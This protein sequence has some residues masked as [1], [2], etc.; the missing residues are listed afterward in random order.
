MSSTHHFWIHRVWYGGVYDVHTPGAA[1]GRRAC[2]DRRAAR[3]IIPPN[4]QIRRIVE[5]EDM[6][7]TGHRQTMLFSATFPKEV[8][9]RSARA[10]AAAAS[11]GNACAVLPTP[12]PPNSNR[13]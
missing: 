12:L 4:S 2:S 1:C 9:R 3:L 10:R 13:R 7:P 5:G 11:T 6:P 8:R